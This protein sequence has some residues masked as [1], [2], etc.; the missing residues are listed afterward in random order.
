M[1]ENQA[2]IKE[3]REKHDDYA[4][5]YLVELMIAMQPKVEDVDA[6]YIK[7]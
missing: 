4:I 6:F 3:L 1:H 5:K 2:N 7:Y